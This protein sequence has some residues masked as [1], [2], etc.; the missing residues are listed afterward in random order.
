M[1]WRAIIWE[2]DCSN[3][4]AIR[5]SGKQAICDCVE[6]NHLNQIITDVIKFT[7]QASDDDEVEYEND[8]VNMLICP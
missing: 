1:T 8:D 6:V 5:P 2:L 3:Y 4:P 7:F